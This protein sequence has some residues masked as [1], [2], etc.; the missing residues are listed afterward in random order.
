M[1]NTLLISISLF[2]FSCNEKKKPQETTVQEKVTTET[3]VSESPVYKEEVVES[4]KLIVPELGEFVLSEMKQDSLN[5]YGEADCWGHI[6]KYSSTNKILAIDSISCG[7]YGYAYRYYVVDEK[8]AI[9]KVYAKS[10]ESIIN[11]KTNLYFYV[12]TELVLDFEQEPAVSK[13]RLDTVY[14]Y[15]YRE[16]QIKKEFLVEVLKNKQAVYKNYETEYRNS[17]ILKSEE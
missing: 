8:E 9:K 13:T 4:K 10:S 17:W 7:Q 6:A 11:P 12:T 15:Q 5:A 2:L 16:Q 3:I 14:D 1:K